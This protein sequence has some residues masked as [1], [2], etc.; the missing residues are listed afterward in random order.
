MMSF[1]FFISKVDFELMLSKLRTG[2]SKKGL[3]TD[4]K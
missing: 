1:P 4:S 2:R 3:G